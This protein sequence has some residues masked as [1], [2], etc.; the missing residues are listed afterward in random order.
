MSSLRFTLAMTGSA[1]A[2]GLGCS[3]AQA[4]RLNPGATPEQF[5]I[6]CTQSFAQ[7]RQEAKQQCGDEFQVVEES[8]NKPPA[9]PVESSGVSS[10]APS[11]GVV[12]WR[13]EWVVR[14]G[15][16]L[17]PLRLVRPTTDAPATAAAPPAI[18]P[19]VPSAQGPERACVPGVTQACLGPGAC[20]GAQACL[21]SG[22]GYGACDCGGVGS[23][24]SSAPAGSSVPAAPSV[25]SASGVSSPSNVPSA[26]SGVPSQP[27]PA[28]R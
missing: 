23:T 26:S 8:S 12:N 3:G 4:Y 9:K 28:P 24:P 17:P 16:Q 20:S 19:A 7:C 13:G 10:T 15:R 5:R 22:E 18:A 1:L 14:C 27:T 25:P 6:V 21:P 11:Q 2:L